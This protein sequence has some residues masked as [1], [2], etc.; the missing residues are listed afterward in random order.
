MPEM[1]KALDPTVEHHAD[2]PAGLL[3][4]GFGKRLVDRSATLR[5]R[6]RRGPASQVSRASVS[7]PAWTSETM[8]ADTG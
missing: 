8:R 7:S 1:L 2:V 6:F 5:S 4:V 3:P